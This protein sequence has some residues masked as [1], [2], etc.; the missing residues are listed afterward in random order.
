[1]RSDSTRKLVMV[2]HGAISQDWKGICY[3]QRDVPLC[4]TWQTG[5]MP[6]V[7]KLAALRPSLVF[8]SGLERTHWLARQV[9]ARQTSS[10]VTAIGDQRLRER[11]FGDWEG[12]AWDEVY[13]ENSEHFHGLVQKPDVYRP[14]NGETTT[15][16]QQRVGAWFDS[17]PE[18]GPVILAISHSGPIASLAGRLLDLHAAQW[19][20]WLLGY[21]DAIVVESSPGDQPVVSVRRVSEAIS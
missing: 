4:P 20:D 7:D 2:R 13:N 5:C 16:M 12:R 14:P 19:N 9:A 10:A 6:L 21:G 3:G 1:M 15:E 11:N 18:H 8:H 17:L